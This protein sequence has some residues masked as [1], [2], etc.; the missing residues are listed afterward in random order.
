MQGAMPKFRSYALTGNTALALTVNC[1]V[2]D[3]RM[4]SLP[5]ATAYHPTGT[6]FLCHLPTNHPIAL[7]IGGWDPASVHAL[8]GDS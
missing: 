1:F 2:Y 3:R 7:E 8:T 6:D 5:G 4:G